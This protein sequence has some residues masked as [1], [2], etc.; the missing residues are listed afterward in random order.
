M[1]VFR[2]AFYFLVQMVLYSQFDQYYN[3]TFIIAQRKVKFQIAILL[4]T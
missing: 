3:F 4:C 2:L 1:I